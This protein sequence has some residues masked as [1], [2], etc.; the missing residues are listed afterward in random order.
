V[1][2]ICRLPDQQDTEIVE[3]RLVC[4]M[5]SRTLAAVPGGGLIVWSGPSGI[6]KTST[7]QWMARAI[8]QQYTAGDDRCYRA[9]HYEVGEIRAN[10]GVQQKQGIRSLYA[11][12]MR[13]PIPD[14]TFKRNPAEGLAE[15]VV[16]A[17]RRR[18]IRLILVDEA[19]CLS[20]DAIRGM[21]L[22]RD[23]AELLKW[24]ASFVFIGMDDLPIKLE[25]LPQIKR[26]IEAWCY[27]EEYGLEEIRQ[28][29]V[30][31]HPHF[32]G[33]AVNSPALKEEV[34]FI[35][36]HF[37][38]LPGAIVPF[39]RQ[40]DARL[41][42]I[43]SEINLAVLIATHELMKRDR[44]RAIADAQASFARRPVSATTSYQRSAIEPARKRSRSKSRQATPAAASRTVP[45]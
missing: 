36:S 27:F 23:V 37:G 25:R 33:L 19:G 12:V 38:G 41:E 42:D 10:T 2:L 39:L 43:G 17:M 44:D 1:S 29:L 9:I 13:S 3:T 18:N 32:R 6:G 20:L 30:A 45:A 16:A 11:Q 24:R 22:V 34:A 31:L 8:E 26:R 14:A 7:A 28:L 4:R 5:A 40:V 35:H 15:L 21:V